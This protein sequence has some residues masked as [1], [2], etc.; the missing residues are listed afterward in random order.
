MNS[1]SVQNFEAAIAEMYTQ[2][3]DGFAGETVTVLPP[4]YQKVK[5]QEMCLRLVTLLFL[6][7]CAAAYFLTLHV[8]S[9]PSTNVSPFMS[10]GNFEA[11]WKSCSI[12]LMDNSDTME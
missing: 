9:D 5:R 8:R 1:A 4:H 12:I 11:M 6:M 7:S 10:V 3:T 2:N